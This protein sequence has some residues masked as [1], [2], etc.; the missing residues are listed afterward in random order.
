MC[1]QKAHTVVDGEVEA[2][3]LLLGVN[4][5]SDDSKQ[6]VKITLS[7]KLPQC[8]QTKTAAGRGDARHDPRGVLQDLLRAIIGSRNLKFCYLIG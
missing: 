7:Q 1:R 4:Y 5:H 6:I 3:N 2:C 8:L